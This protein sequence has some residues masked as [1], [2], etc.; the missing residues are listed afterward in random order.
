M[1]EITIL[2]LPWFNAVKYRW[3]LGVCGS[4]MEDYI[5]CVRIDANIE[6]LQEIHK[7]RKMCDRKTG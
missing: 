5:K 3:L 7:N 6:S 1:R 4:I 2:M